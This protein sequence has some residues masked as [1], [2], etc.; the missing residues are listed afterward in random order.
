MKSNKNHC[1]LVQVSH[2]DKSGNNELSVCVEGAWDRDSALAGV[3]EEYDVGFAS[4][5]D[6]SPRSSVQVLLHICHSDDS[7]ETLRS[8]Q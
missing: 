3:L 7:P 1:Y 5:H 6:S 4:S 8:S 2:I